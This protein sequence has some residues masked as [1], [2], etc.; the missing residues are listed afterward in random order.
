[1]AGPG[2]AEPARFASTSLPTCLPPHLAASCWHPP[3][4]R[5]NRPHPCWRP[6]G[7]GL[8]DLYGPSPEAETGGYVNSGEA[9]LPLPRCCCCCLRCLRCCHVADGTAA[10]SLLTLL[11]LLQL[12]LLAGWRGGSTQ[13]ISL[14]CRRL[15]AERMPVP[16][17]SMAA[18]HRHLAPTP[19][20]LNSSGHSSVLRRLHHVGGDHRPGSG[21]DTG[22]CPS[23]E[24]RHPSDGKFMLCVLCKL[25]VQAL[26]PGWRPPQRGAAAASFLPAVSVVVQ[27]APAAARP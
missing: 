18:W 13:S 6:P 2:A 17:A 22:H 3:G 4:A 10:M 27:C 23:Q 12:M 11:L 9:G 21:A 26:P 19:L 16:T 7:A 1:V 24:R 15:C 5:L 20:N 8:T 14:P 25:C